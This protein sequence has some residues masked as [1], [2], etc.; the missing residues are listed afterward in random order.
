[1]PKTEKST[2]G[3]RF[4]PRGDESARHEVDGGDVVGVEGVSESQGVGQDGGRDHFG[5]VV[6]G[7]SDAGPDEAVDEDEEGDEVQGRAGDVGEGWREPDMGKLEAGH[8]DGYG[9]RE[10][11]RASNL[12]AW[13]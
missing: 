13:R 12:E 2:D 7:Y 1:M 3:Y 10:R 5:E 11:N 9:S 4:L 6:Q 8:G